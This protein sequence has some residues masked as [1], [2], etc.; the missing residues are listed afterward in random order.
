MSNAS[1]KVPAQ[2]YDFITTF[3]GSDDPP[4]PCKWNDAQIR[5]GQPTLSDA[6]LDFMLRSSCNTPGEL[7]RAKEKYLAYLD[8]V[9]PPSGESPILG[10]KPEDGGEPAY[11]LLPIPDDSLSIRLF[12]GGLARSRRTLFFDFVQVH[13]DGSTV[14]VPM[15]K[16]YRVEQRLPVGNIRLKGLH[17]V[18]KLPTPSNGESFAVME[19]ASVLLARPGHADFLFS[20]EI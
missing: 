13:D 1:N 3:P 16:N 6:T 11:K 19:E 14:G 7:A 2:K 5:L 10:R 15:P 9:A 12:P 8:T 4:I 20:T 17:Q 18:L